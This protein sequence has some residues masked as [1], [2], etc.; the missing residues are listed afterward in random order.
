[1]TKAAAAPSSV[2]TEAK[3]SLEVRAAHCA[4]LAAALE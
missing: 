1:M 3:R 4:L 2:A